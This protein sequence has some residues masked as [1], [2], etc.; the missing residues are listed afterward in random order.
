MAMQ[1]G[2]WL[3][4]TL[5]M[6]MAVSGCGSDATSG[7]AGSGGSAGT[8]DGGDTMAGTGGA[9]GG[10]P[11]SGGSGGGG[12]GSPGGGTSSTGGS[13]ASGAKGTGG[14]GGSS[15]AEWACLEVDGACHCQVPLSPQPP[16]LTACTQQ[17]DCCFKTHI[18]N[19]RCQCQATGG[20]TCED[21]AASVNATVVA[22]CPP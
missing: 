16:S 15:A 2:E 13:G 1:C 21:V 17:Y 18:V 5:A 4:V 6:A 8:N 10:A 14:S 19:D 11:D 3:G 7:G 9:S 22:H 20:G 12:A